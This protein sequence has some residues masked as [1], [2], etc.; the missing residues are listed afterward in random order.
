MTKHVG[1]ILVELHDRL[2][3]I[4]SLH[5]YP[6]NARRGDLN[7]I[8]ESLQ[9][10]GQYREIIVQ[11]STRRILAGNHTWEAA[12][13]LGWSHIAAD[14]IDVDDE[15]AQKIVIVDN[16][17]NDQA[18]YDIEQLVKLVQETQQNW[19]LVG[20]G[21]TDEGLDELIES[22][23]ETTEDEEDEDED[24]PPSEGGGLECPNC[25]YDVAR[26]PDKLK[27]V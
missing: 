2:E 6:G 5:Q 19:D 23:N 20:T 8:I 17:S 16:A 18:D 27:Q 26:D 22:L 25:G 14:L 24:Q 10:H 11:K 7:V 21:F 9:E 3:F 13:T 15:T 12:R 4:D 1:K